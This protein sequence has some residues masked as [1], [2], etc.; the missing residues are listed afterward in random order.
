MQIA[1]MSALILFAVGTLAQEPRLEGCPPAEKLAAALTSLRDTWSSVRPESLIPAWH[2]QLYQEVCEVNKGTCVMLTGRSR[3]IDGRPE[4]TET[5]VFVADDPQRPKDLVL[6]S[7]TINYT[8]RDYRELVVSARRFAAAIK[9][10]KGTGPLPSQL[11]G[12]PTA[13]LSA[14][15]D[16]QEHGHSWVAD[17]GVYQENSRWRLLLSVGPSSR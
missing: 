7:V 2:T 9:A 17:L 4:C 8:H 16:W 12:S 6:R 10:P 1:V 14:R 3:V 11:Q 13:P 5:F 15:Y